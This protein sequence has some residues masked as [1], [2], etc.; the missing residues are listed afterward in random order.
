MKM[1]WYALISLIVV[2]LGTLVWIRV[3]P[4]SEDAWHIDL[5]APDFQPP[6]RWATYCPAANSRWAE[7]PGADLARFD[8]IA[9][10]T[11]RTKRA[12]G[13]PETGRITYVTRSAL[14][15]YPDYT[16]V[17]INAAGQLCIVARQR[18]GLEDFGVNQK[19]IDAWVQAYLAANE[20][21]RAP[22]P[23]A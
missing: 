9:L 22:W 15:G 19:R 21:P 10:A 2:G 3:A 11:E 17:A 5:S 18:F 1:W 13:S 14:I 12:Y 4:T 23:S 20:V 16:T 6:K 7:A 8:Q